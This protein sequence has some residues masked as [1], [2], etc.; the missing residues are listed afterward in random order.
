MVSALICF[1][2][3]FLFVA[4][5]SLFSCNYDKEIDHGEFGGLHIGQ[6]QREIIAALKAQGIVNVGPTVRE[7]INIRDRNIDQLDRLENSSGIC[8]TD[9]K[10]FGVYLL[11]DEANELYSVTK[12]VRAIDAQLGIRVPQTKREVLSILAKQLVI[13]PQ[14]MAYNCLPQSKWVALQDISEE[15]ILYLERFDTWSYH[16]PNAYSHTTL[17]FSDSALSK[18]IYHH[19]P[20]DF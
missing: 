3:L 4:L 17:Q 6:S 10:G 16:Q 12:S 11:F 2:R 9:S 5:S 7:S 19:R 13:S 14:L 8:L 20:T 1:G 15:D 18:I